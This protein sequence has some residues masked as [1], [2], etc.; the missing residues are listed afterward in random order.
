L[1]QHVLPFFASLRPSQVTTALV[2][3]YKTAKLHEEMALS[4][5]SLN[6]TLKVLAQVLDEAV[7]VGYLATNP[8]RGKKVRVKQAKPR[9][10]WLELD[11]VRSLLKAAGENRALLAMMILGGLRVGELCALRWRSVNIAGGKLRV[12][13]S[14]TD[15]GERTVDMSPDLIEEMKLHRAQSRQ[16]EPDD[17]VFPT[18]RGTPQNRSNIRSRV[19]GAAVKRANEKRT[20]AGLP[21]IVGVTNHSLRRTFASLLYEA[22]ASPAYVMAQLGH[23]SPALALEVYTKVMERQRDTGQR[24]DALIRGAE[25]AQKG[26]NDLVPTV[27]LA[28]SETKTAS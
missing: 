28:T 14:K 24:M 16:A 8:A 15:A 22:G 26:T 3:D 1:T 21:P 20:E 2:K 23:A 7:D 10:T 9:R 12:E 11:E 6:K 18:R 17:L 5:S 25:W 4:P 19:L 13:K 27:L